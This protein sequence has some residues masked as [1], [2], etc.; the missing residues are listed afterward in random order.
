MINKRL[1]FGSFQGFYNANPDTKD[2]TDLSNLKMEISVQIKNSVRSKIIF[3]THI[4]E[5]NSDVFLSSDDN[6]KDR[7]NK[8]LR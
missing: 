3:M 4:R 7:I 8:M 2:S 6:D 5:F 1:R